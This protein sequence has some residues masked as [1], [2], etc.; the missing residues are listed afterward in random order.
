MRLIAQW[1][2][3]LIIDRRAS[4]HDTTAAQCRND[5]HPQMPTGK[6]H[7]WPFDQRHIQVSQQIPGSCADLS[8]FP[9]PP[10]CGGL[11]PLTNAESRP[12]LPQRRKSD[13]IGR[14]ENHAPDPGQIR[15]HP[16][17]RDL[18]Q[19]RYDQPGLCGNLRPQAVKKTKRAFLWSGQQQDR[20]GHDLVRPLFEE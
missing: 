13:S 12:A 19:G 3:L 2:Q 6:M 14:G 4:C 5:I 18:K 11:C 1:Q 17:A 7:H 10:L 15:L 9:T 20:L 16:G 8:D